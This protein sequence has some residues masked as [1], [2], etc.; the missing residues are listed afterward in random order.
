[1]RL[2]ELQSEIR[3]VDP[4]AI[5][6]S[7]WIL[8]RVIRQEQK[9]QTFVWSVPHREC[10]VVERPVLLDVVEQDELDIPSDKVLPSTVILLAQP[11]PEELAAADPSPLLLKY[12][13]R[14]FHASM[15][16]ALQ[17]QCK[18]GR[19]TPA[20]VRTRIDQ[21]GPVEFEEVRRVLAEDG[22]LL[23]GADERTVYIEF[24]AVFFELH[25]F[26]AYQLPACFP[27]LRDP[28]KVLQLLS[29]DIDALDLFKRSRLAGAPDP[30]LGRRDSSDETHDFYNRLV[31]SAQRA[32]NRGNTVR[33][34]ILY[35]QAARVAPAV[36]DARARSYAQGSIK[37]LVAGLK[38]ALD[39]S[40]DEAAEW[41][42][43]LLPLLDKAD[44]GPR[45]IEEQLLAELQKVCYDNEREVYAL[46]LAEWLLTGGKRPI[47]R[48]LPSQRLVWITKHLRSAAAMLTRARLSDADRQHLAR[49]LQEAVDRSEERLR[50]RF[51][52]ILTET[53]GDV[54]LRPDNPPEHAAF[55]K[56][57]EELLDRITEYGFLTFGDLRDALSRNQVKLPD[58]ADKEDYTKGD[59]LIRLD[60]RLATLL[61][62]VYRPG[63]FYLR[64][65][66]QLSSWGFGTRAGRFVTSWLVTPFGG[67][68][69]LVTALELL[70]AEFKA[71]LPSSTQW[72][73]VLIFGL[74][75]FGLIHV[76]LFRRACLRSVVVLGHA[77]HTVFIHV[78]MR[79]LRIQ[80][81]QRFL[82]SGPFQLFFDYVVKPAFVC[83]LLRLLW[84]HPPPNASPDEQPL[85]WL[86]GGF[87]PF[88]N[89]TR[90]VLTFLVVDVLLNSKPGHAAASALV[91]GLVELYGLLRAGLIPGLVRGVLTLFRRTMDMMEYVLFSVDEW[92]RFRSGDSRF[93]MGVR[94]VITLLWFP[95]SYLTRFYLVVLIEPA[96]N[97]LK[98]P[99]SILFAKFVYPLLAVLG[100]FE[101]TTF[102]SPL[103]D[104]LAPVMTFPVAWFLVIG[105]FYL[106]PDAVT[107]LFW[108]MRGNWRLYRA[109]RPKALGPV[110][111]G[112]HGE[113]VRR[114]LQPGFH[115]G[116]LPKLYA[117]LRRAERVAAATGNWQKVRE[118]G[119]HLNEVERALRR[120]VAREMIVLLRQ[121]PAWR[122]HA[123]I[124]GRV[125][126]ASNRIC[127]ELVHPEFT[128]DSVWL[129]I[130]DRA[131]WLI[132]GLRNPGWLDRVTPAQCQA[133]AIALAGL[134]KLAG[135]DLVREQI[136]ALLPPH[137]GLYDVTERDLVLWQDQR[138][139]AAIL[140]DLTSPQDLLVPTTPD[141][142]P[143]PEWPAL[144]ARQLIFA[145]VK[146]T[147]RQ[148]VETW[149]QNPPTAA[150][151]ADIRVLP[152]SASQRKQ[153]AAS[154][155]GEQE[156][157]HPP[158]RLHGDGSGD[159]GADAS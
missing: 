158:K 143:A 43:D 13:R 47:K 140:Y 147:W 111:V 103:V 67:S 8:D 89:G 138:G 11:D 110:P 115:S 123:L 97:P 65:L 104:R 73:L 70:L 41:F 99:L 53:F 133:A 64:W 56:I 23:P 39:L 142:A 148:W 80:A 153:S 45:P 60:W 14:L 18:A 132:A 27:A 137:V 76:E 55:H 154:V 82:E 69:L 63:E 124:A 98:L 16:L 125:V 59:P 28:E 105:T 84:P 77:L 122:E 6:V 61:D 96:V 150:F 94:A 34:A 85:G 36:L 101:I 37:Y 58:L 71:P 141:D 120:L 93:A 74:V 2:S 15:H 32:A 24:M 3:T 100:L 44:Q 83:A 144:D 87:D 130:E 29:E 4:A 22:Y 109:N 26:A 31:E 68:Y 20:E 5:L 106:L 114:L 151:N 134:Y 107:F 117:R 118:Y 30:V 95:V 49:L 51:R 86:H 17:L 116:T 149:Q 54:G 81:L 159:R 1:M 40:D 7:P 135:I 145:R 127:L 128:G 33:A 88:A 10:Y 91:R 121:T 152:P 57:I 19:L 50:E 38:A 112:T 62:G 129:D 75:L 157:N 48:P 146:I 79:L 35:T 52:P 9:L 12:W 72:T 131:G 139:G 46:D 108:E 66:E 155:N 25:F 102:S 113:T 42:K 126:L 92:L 119:Q 90:T 136:E 21:I 78:P 156:G